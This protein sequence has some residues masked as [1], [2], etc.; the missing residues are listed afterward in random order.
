MKTQIFIHITHNQIT[1]KQA[2][3]KAFEELNKIM[4]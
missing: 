1:N 2:I 4:K 3:R